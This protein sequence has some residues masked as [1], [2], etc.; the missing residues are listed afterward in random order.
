M[1]VIDLQTKVRS[2]LEGLPLE[3]EIHVFIDGS[4]RMCKGKRL[5]GYA[6]VDGANKVLL[7]AGRLSLNWSAQTCKSYALRMLK[8][9][10]SNI[11]TD[12]KYAYGILHIFEKIWVERRLIN[13]IRNWYMFSV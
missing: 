7:E 12:S 3:N 13:S 1:E 11:Y 2:D 6:I 4:I 8:G 9:K 5:N 10:E